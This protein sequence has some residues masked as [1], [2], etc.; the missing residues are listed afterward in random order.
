MSARPTRLRLVTE[1][2]GSMNLA[3]SL[4]LTLAVASII[5]TV[6]DETKTYSEHTADYGSFWFEVFRVLGVYDVYSTGWFLVILVFLLGSTAVCLVRNAP[7]MLRELRSWRSNV[8]YKSVKHGRHRQAWTAAAE[9]D[10]AADTLRAGLARAGYG[11]R[12]DAGDDHTLITARRGRWNRLGYIFTHAAIVIIAVGGLLDSKVAIKI[13][14]LAG[15]I[16]T[17]TRNLRASQIPEESWL[18]EWNHSFR[19]N[20]TV[21]EGTATDV[22]FVNLHGGYLVQ[23]LPFRIELEDFRIQRYPTGQPS[24][25]ESDV[26]VHDP[27]LDEPFATTIS[28]N[29]PLRHRGYSVYQADFSDGGSELELTALPLEPGRDSYAFTARVNERAAFTVDDRV[30]IEFEDFALFNVTPVTGEDGGRVTRNFGPSFD[31]TVRWRDGDSRDYRT[32]MLPVERDGREY[33]LSGMRGG[34]DE[35]FRYIYIPVTDDGSTDRFFAFLASLDDADSVRT[36][37]ETAVADA[38]AGSELDTEEGR[39][40]LVDTVERLVARFRTSG[41]DGVLDHVEERV[42]AERQEQ[43]FQAYL[44]VLQAVMAGLYEDV[45]AD[46]GID[47]PG[48]AEWAFFR[49]ALTAIN[50]LDPYRA[51]WI[52]R[53]DGFEHREA[54]GFQ[55]AR[56]P[57]QNIV[58]FGSTL[59]IIGLFL[60]FY[61]DHRRLWFWLEREQSGTGIL[62]SG[63]SARGTLDFARHFDG[64][65]ERLAR[66][67]GGELRSKT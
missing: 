15:A 7:S 26:V 32:Y 11:T 37:A 20:V 5:G 41:F 12:V 42:P 27:E 39:A 51:D 54:S 56:S 6:V 8:T 21:P 24:E 60:M 13:A 36:T 14:H 58:Y 17:E 28:V 63:N 30:R 18:P 3:I 16:E 57:G 25:Y 33:F 19:G 61:L 40:G 52:L 22:A 10:E 31:Y 45:L 1:F 43:V 9:P 46:D 4:L 48:E 47:R 29:N 38:V 34:P 66:V 62:M 35:D 53:L 64:L 23:P 49:D 65:A 59:L 55:I 44:R 50:G 2:L 67:T